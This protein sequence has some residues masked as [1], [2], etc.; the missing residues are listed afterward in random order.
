VDKDDVSRWFGEYLEVFAAGGRGD[1]DAGAFLA[2]YGVP[3]L[4]P[5]DGGFSARTSA[6]QVVAVAQHQIDGMRAA[7]YH[8]TEVLASDVTVLNTTCALYQ[9]TFSRQRADGTEISRLTVTYLVT[10]AP[11]GRRISALMPHSA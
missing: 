8:H 3:L 1:R 10:D 11:G 5:T 7:G 4:L 9:G 6:E 2:Y